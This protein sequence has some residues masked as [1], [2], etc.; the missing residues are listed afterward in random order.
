[1]IDLHSHV[2]PGF[3]DGVRSVEEARTVVRAAE[4]E[5]VTAIVATPH[6]RDDYP[7]RAEAVER[8]V[9]ALRRDFAEE[10]IGVEIHAG[11]EVSFERV[12]QL[13]DDELRRFTLAQTGRYLLVEFPYRGWPP[14]LQQTLSRLGQQGIRVLLAHPERNAEVQADPARLDEAVRA[15]ALVQLTA[16][17]VDGR[18]G[19]RTRDTATALLER[20]AAHVLATDVHGPR[21]RE[22]GFGE[23]VAAL[24]DPGLARWLTRDVP[25]AIVSGADPPERHE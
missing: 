6:V 16:S 2:L 18:L 8:G 25:L 4:A 3:D 21:L 20:G 17:S 5:G 22:G 10:G 15:G 13:A 24:G 12:W 7:T 11:G 23:A 9:A 19:A 1:M 14:L